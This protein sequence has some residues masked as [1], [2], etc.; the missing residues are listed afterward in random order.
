M[1]RPPI[2][3]GA[4]R[5]TKH[6]EQNAGHG[7]GDGSSDRAP[8]PPTPFQVKGRTLS[9]RTRQ[10]AANAALRNAI[11]VRDIWRSPIVSWAS[12]SRRPLLVE[13]G[14]LPGIAIAQHAVERPAPLA[15][16]RLLR[17]PFRP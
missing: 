13:T 14:S 2:G 12:R 15:T 5:D 7:M 3:L 17:Q 8:R 6:G 11:G 4:W 10:A 1:R 9:I 16:V